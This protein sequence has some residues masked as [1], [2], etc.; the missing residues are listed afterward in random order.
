MWNKL[1][2]ASRSDDLIARLDETYI[3]MRPRKVLPRLV[4]HVLLEGRPLTAALRLLNLFT[5]AQYEVVKRLPQLRRVEKPIFILGLGRSGTTILGKLLSAH[6]D[7]LF[8]NEPK[9]LWHV[10]FP[11]EDII[12]SYKRGEAHYRLEAT[13]AGIKVA[14]VAHKLYS[15]CLAITGSKRIVD[16]YPEMIFRI[17]FIRTIFPDAKLVVIMRNGWDVAASIARWSDQAGRVVHSEWHDWWGVDRRKWKLLVNQIATDD[18]TLAPHVPELLNFTRHEDMAAV[19]WIVTM[20]ET[21]Q[22]QQNMPGLIHV[23]RYEDLCEQ[24]DEVLGHLLEFCELPV[25]GVMLEYARAVLRPTRPHPPCVLSSLIEPLFLE[26][27]QTASYG[28]EA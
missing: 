6:Q 9:A 18:P 10:A 15:Y 19:E 1:F 14:L 25:D 17:P 3:R 23:V 4:S 26:I 21:A 8:L 22:L 28:S 2:A 16:K 11:D 24:P 7:V 27:M 12:G 13:D 20:R 5:F